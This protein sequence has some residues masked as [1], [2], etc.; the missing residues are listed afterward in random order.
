MLYKRNQQYFL[1]YNPANL[2]N[3]RRHEQTNGKAAHGLSLNKTRVKVDED[4][5]SP[6]R[7]GANPSPLPLS[8]WERG[9]GEGENRTI[10]GS[11]S[12]APHPSF[13]PSKDNFANN[14]A[15]VIA[16]SIGREW[17]QYNMSLRGA[18]IATT[19]APYASAVSNLRQHWRLL[20]A[21]ERRPRNDII[22]SNKP[23]DLNYVWNRRLCRAA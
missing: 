3:W 13:F 2:E 17:Q 20:R 19:L 8:Q 16:R 9:R 4:E 5:G 11:P 22:T 21:E 6:L 23:E 12:G 10:S 15:R 1:R 18:F 7:N 14:I